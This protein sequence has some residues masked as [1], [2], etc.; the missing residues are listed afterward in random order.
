MIFLPKMVLEISWGQAIGGF[1]MMVFAASIFALMVL[2]P[3]HANTESEFPFP[4]KQRNYPIAGLSICYK[5]PMMLRTTTG[6]Y[7]F[8][9]DHLIIMWCIICFRISIMFIILRLTKRLEAYAK[10]YELPYRKLTLVT[11]LKNHY[12]LLKKT[13]CR[14]IFSKKRCRKVASSRVR[15]LARTAGKSKVPVWYLSRIEISLL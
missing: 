13:G 4:M 8:L 1:V 12:L 6:L 10:E 15:Q 9:W 2:L 11:A 7:G 5:Q 3:P 14:K